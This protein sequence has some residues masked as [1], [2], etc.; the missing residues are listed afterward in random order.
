MDMTLTR[1]ERIDQLTDRLM[2]WPEL[3]RVVGLSRPQIWRLRQTGNFPS[4]LKL[5]QNRVAWKSSEVQSW[6][7][8][9]ERA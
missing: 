7:D 6:I 2:G 8:S 4:P 3:Q 1:N 5:S 9:R